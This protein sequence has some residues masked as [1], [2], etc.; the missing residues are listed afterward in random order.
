MPL[1]GGGGEGCGG[2][3]HTQQNDELR[4]A[5]GSGTA[6]GRM[7]RRPPHPSAGG[8][9]GGSSGALRRHA[10]G[11]RDSHE[12]ENMGL[13]GG[14]EGREEAAVD[15]MLPVP[16]PAPAGTSPFSIAHPEPPQIEK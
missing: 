10:P 6:R 1:Q 15:G 16:C 12:P 3:A 2:D 4:G 5:E 13:G 7:P 8:A 9:P 11:H 14:E